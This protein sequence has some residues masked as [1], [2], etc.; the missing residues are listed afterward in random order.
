MSSVERAIELIAES[1]ASINRR[2]DSLNGKVDIIMTDQAQ[3]DTDLTALTTVATALVT[4]VNSL[5]TA[6]NSLAAK[7]AAQGSIDLTAEDNEVKTAQTQIQ[8]A[9][10]SVESL[11]NPPTP[12]AP[13]PAPTDVVDPVSK[14]PLYVPAAGTAVATP[15]WNPVAD[16]TG[17]SGEVLYTF[18]SDTAG[19][20]P[21]GA[22]AE[23]LLYTGALTEV[24]STPAAPAAPTA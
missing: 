22:S 14:L 23:W 4:G 11:L 7:V 13:T 20:A 18:A 24:A 9:L 17:P 1:L 8:A 3:F 15:P 21:T 10:A 19:A 2:L 16:V 12:V 6:Y 5:I